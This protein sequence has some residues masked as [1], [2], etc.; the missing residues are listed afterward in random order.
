MSRTAEQRY[1]DVAVLFHWL[2]AF[3]IIGMLLVGKYM[4]HFLDE[5]DPV[6]FQLTQWHKSFG[7][8]VLFLSVLRLIW[9]FTHRP[10]AELASIPSWQQRIAGWVHL[11]LY[12]LMFALPITGWIMSSASPL[13]VDTVLFNVITIP[14][15]P[16]F[17]DLP[18]KADI[19][20]SFHEY[21]ELAGNLLILLLLAHIGAALKHHLI[22]KDS[23]LVRMLP[24]WTSRSFKSKTA[25][26]AMA[27][28]GCTV[29][30]YLYASTDR[31]AALLAA[32]DSEVSFIA[33]LTGDDT[34]GTFA[35]TEVTAS[36]DT[37]NPANSSIVAI[38]NTA[39]LSSDNAQVAGSLPDAEW[40]DVEGHPQARFEST[41]IIEN[42][43]GSLQVSGNLTIK[44]TTEP[45]SFAMSL[46]DEEGK[47]VARGEFTIDR[48][49][50][51]VGM[52]SQDNDDY[53]GF[54]VTVRFRFDIG[55]PDEGDQT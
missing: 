24:D 50:F 7:L 20:A 30:L 41:E 49:Q 10:P 16:P 38:V 14:H 34:P 45:V 5:N 12:G 40:F 54:D 29:G 31:Q 36:I 28:L 33:D 22:D 23:V 1:G 52:Q 25:A 53:V 44:S 32:G 13:N 42:G 46:T 8:T 55:E 2:I 26:L 19:A 6:R 15:I 43:D 48:R 11:L 17:P 21:H 18:N 3:F 27:I 37:Q 9:R 4:T 39:T 51:D 47:Q 35:D